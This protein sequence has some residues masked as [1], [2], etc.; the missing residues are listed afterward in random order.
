MIM[1]SMITE[2]PRA[3]STQIFRQELSLRDHVRA[4]GHFISI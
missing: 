2:I 4:D 3:Y 1:N